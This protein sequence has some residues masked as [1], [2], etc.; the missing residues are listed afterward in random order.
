MSD[1]SQLQVRPKGSD[2]SLS[3]SKARSSLIARGRRDAGTLAGPSSLVEEDKRSKPAGICNK[4]GECK[5]LVFAR[6]VCASCCNALDEQWAGSTATDWVLVAFRGPEPPRMKGIYTRS[7]NVSCVWEGFIEGDLSREELERAIS[8]DSS[9]L[10][11]VYVYS[12]TTYAHM[13]THWATCNPPDSLCIGPMTIDEFTQ[14]DNGG[15]Y[16]NP[17]PHGRAGMHD[18]FP[19]IRPATPQEIVHHSVSISGYS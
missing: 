2:L 10:P 1:E 18:A 4:C 5:A 13:K 6:C 15:D 11:L 7:D 17:W 8:T 3:A 16:P 19:F 12:K 14:G 9:W